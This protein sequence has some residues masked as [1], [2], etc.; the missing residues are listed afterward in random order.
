MEHLLFHGRLK[1]LKGAQLKESATAALNSVNL[2]AGGAGNKQVRT[3]SGGMKRRLSVAIAL[4]GQPTAVYLD[5]P[6]T[7][8]LE[9]C[10]V[11]KEYFTI[12]THC[13][14]T[15]CTPFDGL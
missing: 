8:G 11:I 4:I 2:L 15:L 5:E 10:Q 6:S 1:G 12:A 7:V 14:L 3:Y 9:N 13:I